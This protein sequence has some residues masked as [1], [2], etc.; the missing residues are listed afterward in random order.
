VGTILLKQKNE[1]MQ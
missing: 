1:V